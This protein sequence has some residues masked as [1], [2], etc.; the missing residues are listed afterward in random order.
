MEKNSDP[1]YTISDR[2]WIGHQERK[3]R[4]KERGVGF[5]YRLFDK[6]EDYVNTISARYY[7]DGSEI[8]IKQENKIHEKLRP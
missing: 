1:K 2:L 7:K 4:N 3:K 5:G 6:T 8:L